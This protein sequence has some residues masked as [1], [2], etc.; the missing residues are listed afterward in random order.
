LTKLTWGIALIAVLV[1]TLAPFVAGDYL[2]GTDTR[3]KEDG[4]GE[5]QPMTS[6]RLKSL[7]FKEKNGCFEHEGI[8]LEELLSR[9]GADQPQATPDYHWVYGRASPG[10]PGVPYSVPFRGG[11]CG[12][13]IPFAEADDPALAAAALVTAHVYLDVLPEIG[14]GL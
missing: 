3:E 14:E 12:Y 2:R 8:R 10:M 11:V 13:Y 1:V 7:G 5:A 6:K 9:L 4:G